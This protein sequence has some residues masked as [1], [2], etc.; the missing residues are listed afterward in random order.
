MCYS[1]I[2]KRLNLRKEHKSNLMYSAL[3]MY[4]VL[5]MFNV[6]NLVLEGISFFLFIPFSVLIYL[7]SLSFFC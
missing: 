4:V 7:I 2:A 3:D 5:Q 1:Y 6:K